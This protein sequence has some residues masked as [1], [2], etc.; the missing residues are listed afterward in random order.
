[1]EWYSNWCTN[2][3]L[4]SICPRIYQGCKI[5][6]RYTFSLSRVS[7]LS[8][9]QKGLILQVTV[10]GPLFPEQKN[11][12]SLTL[13]PISQESLAHVVKKE[14]LIPMHLIILSRG[15]DME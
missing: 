14:G 15:N 12:T 11:S 13:Q 5:S 2:I 10:L 7:Y 6:A 4:E 3:G 9:T 1:M 8:I